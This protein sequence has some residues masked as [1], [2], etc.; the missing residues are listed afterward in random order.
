MAEINDKLR[1]GVIGLGSA[2]HAMVKALSANHELSIFDRDAG[3][4]KNFD[5][6]LSSTVNI[7]E[8]ARELA[9]SV[10]VIIF[11]LPTPEASLSVAKSIKDVIRAGSWVVESSTVRPEDVDA[12]QNILSPAGVSVIDAA[13]IGGIHNLEAGNG[14]FLVGA[15]ENAAGE[16]GRMLQDISAEIFFLERQGD[17]MRAKL[18]A[19]A[20]SH[21]A[22]V[23]LLEAGALAASQNIPMSTFV[24]LMERESGLLRPLTHRF[25]GRLKHKDFAGGMSTTNARK[26]SALILDSARDLGVPLFAISAAH[27]AYDLA[28]AEGF[29]SLDYAAIGK[30]WERWLDISYFPDEGE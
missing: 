24:R 16:V 5:A 4:Y 14:V 7:V 23:L 22:Y 30:L 3:K 9:A 27:V 15:I 10:Q 18:V 13:I 25:A 8:S 2:G 29:G 19:N 6:E 28:I 21:T 20:V 12:L 11:C 26:D 1:V 17:G